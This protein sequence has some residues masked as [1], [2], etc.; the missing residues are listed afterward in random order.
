MAMQLAWTAIVPRSLVD[1]SGPDPLAQQGSRMLT[2][3][4]HPNPA[5]CVVQ[6]YQHRRG[7]EHASAA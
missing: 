6:C 1:A 4:P 5:L 7:A 2:V 3:L